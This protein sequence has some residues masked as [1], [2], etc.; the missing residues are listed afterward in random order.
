MTSEELVGTIRDLVEGS[1]GVRTT[2]RLLCLP[3]SAVHLRAWVSVWRELLRSGDVKRQLAFI[4]LIR[5]LPRL[6]DEPWAYAVAEECLAYAAA[7]VRR[8]ARLLLQSWGGPLAEALLERATSYSR[9]TLDA[10]CPHVG[11]H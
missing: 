9:Q 4:G 11:G 6:R 1:T 3:H 2:E 8:E 5:C 10:N 7:P